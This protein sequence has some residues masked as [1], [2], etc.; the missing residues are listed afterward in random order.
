M[1]RGMPQDE[2]TI[3]FSHA[4]LAPQ[5]TEDQLLDAILVFEQRVLL[6]RPE[7]QF[8]AVVRNAEGEYGH[9]VVADDRAAFER[10][11]AEAAQ[12]PPFQ[13]LMKCLDGQKMR[14]Y[15]H[16][17]LAPLSVPES[18][19]VFEH[20]V[21]RAKTPAQ[22]DRAQLA[23]DA[24]RVREQ[25]LSE[26]PG[27]LAQCVTEAD[28]ERYGELVFGASY[29]HTRRSCHGYLDA[30]ACQQMLESADPASVQLDFWV[31]LLV[32]HLRG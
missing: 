25:Y 9:L 30:P 19:G 29:A 32:R 10:I 15:M 11:M 12:L 17:P 22:F 24:V 27:Y 5:T 23:A 18:F 4:P 26:Q 21:F 14:L 16:R 6:E 1:L 31:P 8:H 13:Q 28:E 2:T 3:E 20:G 7:F